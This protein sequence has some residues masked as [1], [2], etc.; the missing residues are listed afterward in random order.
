MTALVIAALVAWVQA[1]PPAPVLRPFADYEDIGYVIMAAADGHGADDLKRDLARHL[2][3]DVSL[4]LYGPSSKPDDRQKILDDYGRFLPGDRLV[5][6]TLPKSKDG[7]WSRDSLPLPLLDAHGGLVLAD[8]RYWSGFEPD[9]R[10]GELFAA[11]VL[12]HRQQ[13]EGGNFMANHLGDCFVVHTKPTGKIP[14]AMFASHYGCRSLTRLPK[15]GGIGHID[16]RARFVSA[17]TVVTDTP[18]Y[19]PAFAARGLRVV[20][21]PRPPGKYETYVNALFVN[22]VAFVPQYGRE[23]DAE[24]ARVYRDLGF[25]VVG[26]DSR[27]LSARGK[28]SLHCIAMTYPRG[29]LR[30]PPVAA[31]H[32]P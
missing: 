26:L 19:E 23:S 13:F 4:V 16:E 31:P 24:A 8:A 32:L 14:E 17:L 25:A 29:P 21:L 30:P 1:A 20:R 22:R 6:V 18:E 9:A 5:Y 3:P 15:R 27:T 10:I 11:R 7:F 2:P 12:S 28:G